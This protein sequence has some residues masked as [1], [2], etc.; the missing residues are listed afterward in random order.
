MAKIGD[1]LLI[2][3]DSANWEGIRWLPV[4]VYD[5]RIIANIVCIE[6]CHSH[7]QIIDCD[8]EGEFIRPEFEIYPVSETRPV[9]EFRKPVVSSQFCENR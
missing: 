6:C 9:S 2:P 1:E 8:D 5:V 4:E 3:V 7:R